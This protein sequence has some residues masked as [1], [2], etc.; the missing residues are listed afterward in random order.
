M[1]LGIAVDTSSLIAEGIFALLFLGAYAWSPTGY[2]IDGGDVVIRRLIGNVRIPVS[3]IREVRIATRDDLS[4]SM[5]LF[6]SGGLFGYYGL[7]RNSKLGNSD[8]YVTDRSHAVVLTGDCE[9]AIVSPD[10]Q[11]AFIAALGARRAPKSG[12]DWST[13]GAHGGSGRG[14]AT[15]ASLI[16]G[17]AILGAIFLY[18]PGPPGYTLTKDSLEIH[19]R[20]FPVTLKAAN[21]DVGNVRVI[22]FD[23]DASWRPVLRV[24][25]VGAPHYRAGW[26]RVSSGEKKRLRMYRAD[27]KTRSAFALRPT[28]TAHQSYWKRKIPRSSSRRYNLPGANTKLTE[29]RPKGSGSHWMKSENGWETGIR[30]PNLLSLF[31]ISK[32]LKTRCLFKRFKICKEAPSYK[33]R[34]NFLRHP[35]LQGL[36]S[37]TVCHE[38]A[39]SILRKVLPRLQ[40]R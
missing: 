29:P 40:S 33:V 30:T 31:V 35:C 17:A 1:F 27:S 3:G 13:V 37:T 26:F 23:K 36:A 38:S 20:L 4:G 11:A 22:D 24:G 39:A 2:E 5:R 32:L 8:W 18:S 21:V 25:G 6:G 16:A 34:H 14:W 19:D 9:P 12:H 7:F 10:D 15:A 28:A